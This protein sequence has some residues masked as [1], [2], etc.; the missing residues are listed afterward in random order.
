MSDIFIFKERNVKNLHGKSTWCSPSNIALIKYWGKKEIQIPINPSISFTLTNC[1]TTCK[2]SYDYSENLKKVDF[3]FYF[4]NKKEPSFENKLKVFFE[5]INTYCPFLKQLKLRI[6]TKNSFPHSSGIAS[7]ASAYSAIALCVMDIEKKLDSSI[8][9]EY[10]FKKASFLARLGSGSACRS[11]YGPI[12]LWGNTGVDIKSS[13]LYGFKYQKKIHA[14]F[15]DY[16]DTI[17]L[18]DKGKKHISS[19]LGHSLME[20]HSFSKN[21]LTQ[22]KKNIT[23]LDKSLVSGDLDGFI[24]IVELEALTLHAMMMTS[25]PYYVLIKPNSLKIINEIWNYR[26]NNNSK[27]CFT[28]DAGANIHLLYPKKEFLKIQKFIKEK[29]C[30][31]CENK[32][33]INDQV[34]NGP[35]KL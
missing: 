16:Q 32:E 28:L 24:N 26:K 12:T 17:L 11:L 34:G 21:R 27:V 18:V 8:S 13:D 10:F 4:E 6:E 23:Y 9:S 30:T 25:N 20:N 1:N 31:Y 2:L 14:N 19:T 29:L 7:S 33:F 15:L 35:N 5:R 3:D 22:V